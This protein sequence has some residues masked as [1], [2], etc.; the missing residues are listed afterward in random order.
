M[1]AAWNLKN[2]SILL[3]TLT[4]SYHAKKLFCFYHFQNCTLRRDFSMSSRFIRFS[5]L[6]NNNALKKFGRDPRAKG[7][8]RTY[9]EILFLIVWTSLITLFTLSILLRWSLI[10]FLSVFLDQPFTPMSLLSCLSYFSLKWNG[11]KGIFK[12]I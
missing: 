6:N 10:M 1:H 12:W 5:W 4:S 8:S 11:L 9:N 3:S 2:V 7:V